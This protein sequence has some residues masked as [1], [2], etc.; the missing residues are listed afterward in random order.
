MR[1]G[2]WGGWVQPCGCGSAQDLLDLVL[3]GWVGQETGKRR[4]GGDVVRPGEGD[5]EGLLETQRSTP[6]ASR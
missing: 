2:G 1:A 3:R 6:A 4:N 5:H